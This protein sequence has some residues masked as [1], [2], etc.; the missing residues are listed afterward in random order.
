MRL[1]REQVTHVAWLCRLALTD[2]EID[3]YAEQLSDI[4][5]HIQRLT[6]LDVEAIEPT[7]MAVEVEGNVTR[8]DIPRPA[9]PQE[10]VLA[11][12]A[13][14]EQG[15]FRVRAILEDTA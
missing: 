10:E 3:R 5:S 4:L 6:E 1:D 11:N 7:A 13:D 9:A 8:P 12:A 2:E 15:C 14:T